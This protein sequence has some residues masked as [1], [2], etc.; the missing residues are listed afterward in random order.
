MFGVKRRD[1]TEYEFY[2]M[3]PAKCAGSF[4]EFYIMDEY[5]DYHNRIPN[6]VLDYK[7]TEHYTYSTQHFHLYNAELFCPD[8]LTTDTPLYTIVRN[9]YDRFAS[10]LKFLMMY[11]L[12]KPSGAF[13]FGVHES[14]KWLSGVIMNEMSPIGNIFQAQNAYTH[15]HGEEK[16]RWFRLEDIKDYTLTIE[17]LQF[18]MTRRDINNWSHDD[19]AKEVGFTSDL[20]IE[21]NDGMKE[22]VRQAYEKDFEYYGYEI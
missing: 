15:Y 20:N 18:D 9:P 12:K 16:T 21:L 7:Q 14:E 8:L 19:V 10:Q 13:D 5:K 1:A 3:H 4:I 22:I 2:F 6:D 11:M 17:S